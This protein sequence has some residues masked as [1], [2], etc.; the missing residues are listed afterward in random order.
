MDD[1]VRVNAEEKKQILRDHD[2]SPPKLLGVHISGSRQ[3]Q[4][5]VLSTGCV[6]CAVMFSAFQESVY[7]VPGFHFSGWMTFLTYCV[8]VC[9]GSLE[10]FLAGDTSRK[11]PLKDY[12]IV[13]FT[14]MCGVYLTNWALQYLNYTVRVVFKSSKVIP[15][16]LFGTLIQG[17]VYSMQEYAAGAAL[18]MG[19]SVF[20]MGGASGTPNFSPVGIALISA[21]LV[22][23]AITS[24]LEERWFFRRTGASQAEVMTF[25]STFGSLYTFIALFVTGEAWE[26]VPH[27]VAHPQVV[28]LITV[29]SLTAYMSVT[30]V[31]LLIKHFNATTA[32]I[33]KSMRKVLQVLVSFVVFPKPFDWKYVF[34]GAATAAA[35][36]W[37]ERVKRSQALAAEA[38]SPSRAH[39]DLSPGRPGSPASIESGRQ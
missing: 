33:V 34:G 14:G 38:P 10:R 13:A 19:I 23:D 5:A 9:C 24:N 39:M 25:M 35:L 7:R 11:V 6:A 4:F 18:V 1:Q 30:F 36:W 15:V 12:A 31:L 20:T 29:F 37:F 28:L 21:A 17:R 3:F 32:E 2:F 16:M 8:F 26:A 27:S 22:C